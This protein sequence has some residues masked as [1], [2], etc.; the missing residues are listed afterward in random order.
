MLQMIA[1]AVIR[2]VV[3][4]INKAKFFSII[5]DETTDVSNQEQVS[6]CVRYVDE[7]L[8]VQEHILGLYATDSTDSLTLFNVIKSCVT[9]VGL[10]L[11]NCR[12]LTCVA[13]SPVCKHGLSRL[14][15]G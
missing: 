6:I 11:K 15:R 13:V 7:N 1:E 14:I 9:S 8:C 4:D 12:G 5:A 10:D 2:G 3:A